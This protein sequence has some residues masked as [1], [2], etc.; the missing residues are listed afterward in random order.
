[1]DGATGAELYNSGTIA[2]TGTHN[3]GLAVANKRVYF[4]THDNT[5]YCFGFF[6]DQPQLTGR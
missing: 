5:V 3:S 2:A 4:T 1:M 6:A